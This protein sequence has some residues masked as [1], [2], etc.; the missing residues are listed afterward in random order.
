[1]DTLQ[2]CYVIASHEFANSPYIY[3]IYTILYEHE[4]GSYPNQETK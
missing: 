1:M 4:D 3:L 2:G